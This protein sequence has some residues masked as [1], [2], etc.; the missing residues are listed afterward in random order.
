MWS[1]SAI[2]SSSLFN[3]THPTPSPGMIPSPPSPKLLHL[4]SLDKKFPWLSATYLF[5]WIDTFT[6]PA[7][8]ISHSPFFRLSTARCSAVNDEEHCVST[9][10]LGPSKLHTYDTR[11]AM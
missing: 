8:A 3:S 9:A 11:L 7:S 2:A 5:G 10:R 4:P 1:P 6:P